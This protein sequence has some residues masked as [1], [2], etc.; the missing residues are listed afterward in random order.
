MEQCTLHGQLLCKKPRPLFKAFEPLFTK[1]AAD[2]PIKQR[3]VHVGCRPGTRRGHHTNKS[4][5]EEEPVCMPSMV[6]SLQASG[7]MQAELLLS[8]VLLS[9]LWQKC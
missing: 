9:K 1:A 6:A 3:F 8:C 2:Q 7:L 4:C 5:E